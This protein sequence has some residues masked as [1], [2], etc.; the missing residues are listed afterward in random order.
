MNETLSRDEVG[1]GPKMLA[2]ND[3][4]RAFVVAL[5]SEE[6]P[7]KGEGRL[8]FAAHRAGYGTGKSTNSVLSV[9]ASRLVHDA[10]IQQA[11]R[12]FAPLCAGHFA[13]G[14]YSGARADQR[15]KI[16]RPRACDRDGARSHRPAG[17]NAQRQDRAFGPISKDRGDRCEELMAI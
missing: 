7:P 1:W 11:R 14:R 5:Y 3:R 15:S 9:I 10:K 6:V 17:N 2:L 4:Q 16:A 8:I 12:I 13:R